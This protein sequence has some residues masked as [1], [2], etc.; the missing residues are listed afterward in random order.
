MY[1]HNFHRKMI[2]IKQF[3]DLRQPERETPAPAGKKNN[4]G[5]KKIEGFPTAWVRSFTSWLLS[6]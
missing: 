3:Y 6:R 5:L 4:R 1:S 2:R